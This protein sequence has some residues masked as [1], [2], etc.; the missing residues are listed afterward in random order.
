MPSYTV[1]CNEPYIPKALSNFE[2]DLYSM[3]ALLSAS[4]ANDVVNVNDFLYVH[5]D[6]LTQDIYDALYQ[7]IDL[8]LVIY[9]YESEPLCKVRL[10]RERG[11]DAVKIYPDNDKVYKEFDDITAEYTIYKIAKSI[12]NKTNEI[13]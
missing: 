5:A 9:R 11:A 12:K 2:V 10:H 13:L 4:A 8:S 7:C 1:I 3:D 6:C